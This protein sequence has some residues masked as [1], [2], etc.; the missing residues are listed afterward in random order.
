MHSNSYL[1]P[2]KIGRPDSLVVEHMTAEREV[3][4]SILTRVAVLYP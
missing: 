1:L 4:G 2:L 3:R